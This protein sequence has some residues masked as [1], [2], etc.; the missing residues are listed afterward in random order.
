MI[1]SDWRIRKISETS[2]S[3]KIDEA[4]PLHNALKELYESLTDALAKDPPPEI[5]SGLWQSARETL[6]H[7][8][9]KE[10]SAVKIQKFI[11]KISNG[12]DY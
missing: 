4:I 11:G 9:N 7:W 8:I 5:R 10:Y 6:Q 12:L 1:C 3:E 2:S